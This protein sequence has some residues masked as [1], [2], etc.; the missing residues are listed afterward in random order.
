LV[1]SLPK[2][3]GVAASTQELTSLR[4]FES[5]PV[6]G[7]KNVQIRELVHAS[8]AE[9]LNA[10]AAASNLSP[11]RL[12]EGR[13]TPTS[14]AR[15]LN[16]S[17]QEVEQRAYALSSQ[18]AL[19]SLNSSKTANQKIEYAKQFPK[20]ATVFENINGIRNNFKESKKLNRRFRS[21]HSGN[22]KQS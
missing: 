7:C 18:R 10:T 5:L 1:N 17:T 20:P 8:S 3:R 13:S 6:S 15:N 9:P 14:E 4:G 16:A 2:G 22:C 19:A 21:L 12:S 11:T